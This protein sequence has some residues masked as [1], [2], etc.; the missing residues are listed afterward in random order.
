MIIKLRVSDK[1]SDEYVQ[2]AKDANPNVKI[3]PRVFV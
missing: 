3:L 2:R 1:F